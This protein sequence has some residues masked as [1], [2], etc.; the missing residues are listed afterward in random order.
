MLFHLDEDRATRQRCP[1]RLT[2]TLSSLDGG[3]EHWPEDLGS[4]SI[5]RQL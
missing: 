1:L 2:Y 3:T 5:Y 4:I